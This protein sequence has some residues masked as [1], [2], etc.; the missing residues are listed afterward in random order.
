[1]RFAWLSAVK[2]LRR[3]RRDPA[4][5]ITWI[6]LPLFTAAL[7][8]VAFGGH[9]GPTPQGRLLV[10]D[11][12]GTLLS[13]LLTGAFSQGE[14]AKMVVVEKVSREDGRARM[15]RGD[16]S[17]LLIVPQGFGQAV[18][19]SRPFQLKLVT[20]PTQ[21]I[22]PSIVQESVSIMVEAAFYLQAMVGDQLRL[23]AEGPPQGAP[24][25]PDQTI[26]ATSLA[27]NRIGAKLGRYL[28]PPLITLE[29]TVTGEKSPLQINFAAA[30]F[31]GI[32]VLTILFV[33]L[34]QS[35]D[36]WK[37]REHGTLRRLLATSG[38]P[39]AFLA[40]KLLAAVVVFLLLG[41][42]GVAGA[43]W[44]LGMPA[45]NP[46]AAVLWIALSGAGLWVMFAL[47]EIHASSFR[48]AHILG[49]LV[50]FPL[51]MLGG[52]YFPFE[53]M[54]GWLARIG[55]LT[56]NGW[57]VLELRRLLE[58]PLE[59]ARLAVACAGLAVAAGVMFPLIL[60]RLRR[61]FAL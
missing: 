10:A 7:L 23:F 31:P 52:S 36:L 27:F 60:R 19:L 46:V 18:L 2:D 58:G 28:A 45:V 38:S 22:L 32:L 11:E 47:L 26:I 41:A 3:L 9:A 37:E 49:F 50:V 48:A 33:V 56:P 57:V 35:W 20:N 21:R 24:A 53:V 40:G 54:P 4:A 39:T 12:D 51:V 8:N 55:R 61:G 29:T 13:S 6:G 16:G 1:M 44:L 15:D 59:P 14:L 43:H 5:L 34:G 17:A 42:V 30:V 25:F